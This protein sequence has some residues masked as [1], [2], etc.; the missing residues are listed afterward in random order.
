[1]RYV[2]DEPT[3]MTYRRKHQITAP[4][5][6]LLCKPRKGE[7]EAVRAFLMFVRLTLIQSG[8]SAMV[9]SLTSSLSFRD[10]WIVPDSLQESRN[11]RFIL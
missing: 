2:N 11:W 9:R 8:V 6:T 1:M 4:T 7:Q 3:D 10:L 5:L